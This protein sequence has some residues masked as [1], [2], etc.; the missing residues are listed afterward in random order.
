MEDKSNGAAISNA[1]IKSTARYLRAQQSRIASRLHKAIRRGNMSMVDKLTARMKAISGDLIVVLDRS[2]EATV[3]AA[4]ASLNAGSGTS[5]RNNLPPHR[6][7]AKWLEEIRQQAVVR[8]DQE[9]QEQFEE[10]TVRAQSTL[11]PML[12]ASQIRA[13]WGSATPCCPCPWP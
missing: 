12:T 10:G 6:V 3:G 1:Q 11:S 9:L 2:D 7:G 5:R 4:V 13:R 8:R